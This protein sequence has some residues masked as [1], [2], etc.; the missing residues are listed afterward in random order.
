[1]AHAS[2]CRGGVG[3]KLLAAGCS[4]CRGCSTSPQTNPVS[5]LWNARL[6][7]SWM[8][9][10][11]HLDD[12]FSTSL[13]HLAPPAATLNRLFFFFPFCS[14]NGLT[15]VISW[16]KIFSFAYISEKWPSHSPQHSRNTGFPCSSL[17]LARS[18]MEIVSDN[19][20]SGLSD[21]PTAW[22]SSLITKYRDNLHTNIPF[23]KS[24]LGARA[25]YKALGTFFFFFV[26]I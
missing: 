1:M 7:L 11:E 16:V 21:H 22:P 2:F 25:K 6:L 17:L 3:W 18:W 10:K 23:K 12:Q 14:R 8:R 15:Q 24:I 20:S 5:K 19:G 26:F 13:P 4:I 9:K